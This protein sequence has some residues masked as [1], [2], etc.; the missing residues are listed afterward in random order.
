MVERIVTGFLNTNT[1]LFSRWKKGCLIIDP[2]GNAEDIVNHIQI[3]N[4][5][6]YAI[7][8][9]HGHFDHVGAVGQLQA[10]YLSQDVR[11][12]VYIHEGDREFLG[13]SAREAHTRNF[14]YLGIEYNAL[15]HGS[16]ESL[17]E[18]DHLL[19]EGERLLDTDL[20]VI[21]TPG[22]TSGG[23]SLYSEKD[24][25]LFSGDSLFFEGIG[26][27]DLPGGDQEQLLHNIREKLFTLPGE[28]RVFPGH[29][30]FTSIEREKHNNPFL[31]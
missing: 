17:P 30:P 26:R 25:I 13:S 8:L 24:K 10:H 6:P 7:I 31:R 3:K 22:H 28:T 12:P 4:F 11:L 14:A 19:E 1:Y 27:C 2:G 16:L 9:T 20:Q 21:H 15:F 5:T 29:G 23:I 18:P